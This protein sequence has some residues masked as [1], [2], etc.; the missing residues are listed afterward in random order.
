MNMAISEQQ[1]ALEF[2]VP[3]WCN[4]R[5]A[6]YRP[7]GWWFE[8]LMQCRNFEVSKVLYDISKLASFRTWKANLVCYISGITM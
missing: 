7:S 6:V 1:I 4:G 8:T 3:R 5:T 2:S